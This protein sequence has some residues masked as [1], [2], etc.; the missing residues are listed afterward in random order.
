MRRRKASLAARIRALRVTTMPTGALPKASA[1]TL[2][3]AWS[4]RASARTS[5]PSAMVV[6]S[7][8]ASRV[9]SASDGK[10]VP[11]WTSWAMS[12]AA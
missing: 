6:A 10:P 1:M 12:A 11:A 4:E 2:A 8:K 5:S 3:D 9:A 7:P